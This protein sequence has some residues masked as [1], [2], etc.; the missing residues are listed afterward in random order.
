VSGF[1]RR[2]VLL[3]LALLGAAVLASPPTAAAHQPTSGAA[4]YPQ[5]T[6]ELFDWGVG[7][8]GSSALWIRT[9]LRAAAAAFRT[10]NNS[11]SPSFVEDDTIER[12]RWYFRPRSGLNT[13]ECPSAQ[14]YVACSS[15]DG[16]GQWDFIN[17]ADNA[18]VRF[19]L[20]PPAVNPPSNC[21]DVQRV[22]I[23]ELGH[24][25]GLSRKADPPA[26]V[27]KHSTE[28]QSYSVM[29][30]NTPKATNSGWAT[31]ALQECDV[32]A[33]QLDYDVQNTAGA[34]PWCV[35]HLPGETNPDGLYS[36]TT[37]SSASYS[38]CLG[39]IL[40]TQGRLALKTTSNYGLISNNPLTSRTLRFDRRPPG[41]SWTYNVTSTTAS[42]VSGYNWT[43]TWSTGS[44]SPITYEIRAHFDGE[45]VTGSSVIDTS[46]VLFT[47]SWGHSC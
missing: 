46:E 41:G 21:H 34:Y 19:C 8:D 25:G 11:A 2:R 9:E 47:I 33:L 27:D 26:G 43:R 6:T 42:N 4:H 36:V 35:D 10:G 3:P 37:R 32:L 18:D 17:L 14:F 12:N 29:Q 45:A 30:L 5:S 20:E 22:A 13:V 16:N 28:A 24:I 1:E 38:T 7:T 44:Q 15:Y 23:H 40:T 39:Q 31:H